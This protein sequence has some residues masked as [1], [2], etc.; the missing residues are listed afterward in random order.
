MS[1]IKASKFIHLCEGVTKKCYAT[2]WSYGMICVGCNCCGRINKDKKAV[3]KARLRFHKEQLK[4]SKNFKFDK[5]P[6]LRTIQ[7]KNNK[8]SIKYDEKVIAKLSKAIKETK[9]QS[10]RK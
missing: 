8:A 10:K 9:C 6:K 3:Y 7:E 5:N 2:A 1:K 4:Y